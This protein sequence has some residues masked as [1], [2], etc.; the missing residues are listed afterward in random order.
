MQVPSEARYGAVNRVL[1]R[2]PDG[3]VLELPIRSAS[4]GVAWAFIEAPR[5]SL[6]PFDGDD[7]VNGYSGFEP[8][9]F[10]ERVA[11]LNTFPSSEALA[12]ADRLGV[13]Y[14]VLRTELVGNLDT[15]LRAAL[16]PLGRYT[17]A[18]AR[19]VIAGIPPER[20]QDVTQV[21][22]AYIVELAPPEHG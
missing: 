20:V 9:G 15:S 10:G 16:Q 2:R 17:G 1:S 18:E 22:G 4:D 7:R 8:P 11:T 5:Q 14:V 3:V 13:R 19:G 6:A 21:K 12:E